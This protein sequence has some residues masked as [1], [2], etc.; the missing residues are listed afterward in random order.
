MSR[1]D[2]LSSPTQGGSG[3]PGRRNGV[4]VS[5]DSLTGNGVTSSGGPP[6]TGW[7]KGR[8]TSLTA[9]GPAG[10]IDFRRLY[11]R[12]DTPQIMT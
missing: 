8:S 5:M 2:D 7:E 1:G 12:R 3:A 9:V 6:E 11:T 10:P 4:R